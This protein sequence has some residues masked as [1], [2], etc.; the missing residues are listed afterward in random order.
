[1]DIRQ[2]AFCFINLAIPF[3]A[4]YFFFRKNPRDGIQSRGPLFLVCFL[5]F[6]AAG[7]SSLPLAYLR[8]SSD[9]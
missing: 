1:M 8:F 2:S 4:G 9:C 7:L 5:P 6:F 3:I